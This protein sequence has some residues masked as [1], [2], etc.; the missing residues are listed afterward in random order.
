MASRNQPTHT[1]TDKLLDDSNNH[2]HRKHKIQW[3]HHLWWKATL[4]V[5]TL[6]DAR[7]NNELLC[8]CTHVHT[9]TDIN[10]QHT[11]TLHLPRSPGFH[12]YLPR[13]YICPAATVTRR[14]PG[15]SP[16]H[17]TT[18]SKVRQ[19][20]T[21]I[22]QTRTGGYTWLWVCA[23]TWLRVAPGSIVI[24]VAI[25]HLHGFRQRPSTLEL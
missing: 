12:K 25:L 17:D 10:K 7:T 5:H 11:M 23:L 8:I 4:F 21:V 2:I 1:C 20:N 14:T 24:T 9:R 3:Q 16:S 18:L 22:R 15:G 19:A 13:A 6:S